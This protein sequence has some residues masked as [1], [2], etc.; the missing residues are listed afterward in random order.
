MHGHDL[1]TAASGLAGCPFRLHGRDPATGLDCIGLLAAAL[2]KMGCWV[3]FPTGYRVRTGSFAG[4]AA[5][6][7]QHGFEPVSETITAG[8]V[9]FVAPGPSQMHLIIA[10][11]RE[12]HFIEAHAGIGRVV[13]R[14]GPLRDP[15]IQHWRLTAPA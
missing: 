11:P 15:I 12:G 10:A 13:I 14:P 5:A 3:D 8:D 7:R 4:L 9:L 1:A 2:A 6:A